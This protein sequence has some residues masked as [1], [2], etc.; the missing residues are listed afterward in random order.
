MIKNIKWSLKWILSL[1]FASIVSYV[2][3]KYIELQGGL[4]H[5]LKYIQDGILSLLI[6]QTPL[7]LTLLILILLLYIYVKVRKI[8]LSLNTLIQENTDLKNIIDKQSND[9]AQLKRKTIGI[10]PPK[11]KGIAD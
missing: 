7:W 3:W 9:I 1:V 6:Q 2:V 8:Y 11:I 5:L 4:R 10:I